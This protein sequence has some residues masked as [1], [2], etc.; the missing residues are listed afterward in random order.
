MIAHPSETDTASRK[1]GR[2]NLWF[3]LGT[4]AFAALCLMVWFPQDIASGFL[5]V[6]LTGRTVPG[7]AFFPV[8]LV[9]LMIPLALLLILSQLRGGAARAGETVGRIGAG[10]LTY[11]ARAIV[12]TAVS[13]FVMSWTGP[14]LVWLTNASG[15]TAYSGYRAVS[16][17][18][19]YDVSGFF[20]GG[21]LLSAGFIHTTR[22]ALRPRDVLIAA[23]ST[24]LLVLIFDGL[25]ENIQ[26]PPNADL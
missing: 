18:F 20:A 21:T 13:L 8:L 11:L 25:L 22:H 26:L 24:A 4:L 17:T 12:L 5:Q 2:W 14:M 1:E 15:L 16:G 3:G 10:N 9:G 19:P 6:N 23:L 7:D